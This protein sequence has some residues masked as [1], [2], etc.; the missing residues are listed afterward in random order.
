MICQ[1]CE[2]REATVRV[3]RT[4]DGQEQVLNLCDQCADSA[5]LTMKSPVSWWDGFFGTSLPGPSLFGYP[6]Q[7]RRQRK[8]QLVC[9]SC[10]ETEDELRET[11]LLG[12]PVCYDT[13]AHLLDPV[14]GRLHGHTSHGLPQP[15]LTKNQES[16]DEAD[17]P[18]EGLRRDL[19]RAVEGEAY[20]EAARIRDEIR[21]L[22]S[23]GDQGEEL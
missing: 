18:L 6:A 2:E 11:G 8:T 21:A 4:L 7:L 16:Q 12:C 23:Q 17:T 15:A 22:E 3:R 13:F 5:G 20:E 10:G 14:F 1:N 9:P 19:A